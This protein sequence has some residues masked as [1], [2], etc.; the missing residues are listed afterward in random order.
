MTILDDFILEGER[1]FSIRLENDAA[2][3]S[4]QISVGM[5]SVDVNVEVDSEDSKYN[6]FTVN[7]LVWA[8]R[9]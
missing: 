4:V 2:E 5:F 8:C 9:L 6:I 1:N 7:K 3:R